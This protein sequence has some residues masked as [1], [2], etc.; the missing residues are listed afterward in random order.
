MSWIKEN[1]AVGLILEL[2]VISLEKLYYT[3]GGG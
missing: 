2:R 3:V 1:S